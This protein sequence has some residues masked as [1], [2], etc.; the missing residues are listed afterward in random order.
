MKHLIQVNYTPPAATTPPSV[1]LTE[2]DYDILVYV[3]GFIL[4]KL[5]KNPLTEYLETEVTTSGLI[6]TKNRLYCCKLGNCDLYLD[7]TIPK[8]KLDNIFICCDK[9]KLRIRDQLFLDLSCAQT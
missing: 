2:R 1:D 8:V 7:W 6:G 5:K 4:R 9:H 3:A